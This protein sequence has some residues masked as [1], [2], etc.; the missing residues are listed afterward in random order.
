MAT[1][2]ECSTSPLSGVWQPRMNLKQL[3]YGSGCVEKHLVSTLPAPT[4]KVIVITGSSI[5]TT[6]P[7]VEQLRQ[8]LGRCY[9]GTI[10]DIRQHGPIEDVDRATSTVLNTPAVDTLIS[11]GGGTPIDSA[12]VISYR[13]KERRGRYLTHLT[14][15]TTLSAAECTAGGGYTRADGVKVGYRAVEM[16]VSAIF[17]DPKF[18]AYTPRDLWLSTGVRALDHA[19]ECFYHPYAAELPWKALSSWA[20]STLFECLPKARD[21]HPQDDDTIT[22][23]L[24]AAYASSGL[25]GENL[26]G[27]MGLSHSIGHALASPYGIPY[28]IAACMTLGRVVKLKATE[29]DDIATQIARLLPMMGAAPSGNVRAD[30]T[31]V[32]DRIMQLVDSLRLPVGT[33][34]E[35]GISQDEVPIIVQRTT[36]GPRDG[37]MYDAVEALI[38]SLF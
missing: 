31:A 1:P 15:P 5:A 35:R 33:L 19:V 10:S 21:S 20:V 36:G 27:G 24:L 29:S 13:F 37:P 7:L 16:G 4:S 6:T 8:L 9:V 3:F 22:R 17:Y 30:A 12:K 26:K 34:T 23:L 18:A 11:V 2:I 28:G 38:R 14:I 25:K 32:G